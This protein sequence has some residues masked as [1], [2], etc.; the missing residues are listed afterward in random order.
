MRVDKAERAGITVLT[1]SG[2]MPVFDSTFRE[3]VQQCLSE[4]RLRFLVDLSG[5]TSVSDFGIGTVVEGLASARRMGGELKLLRPSASFAE[6]L[7][8]TRLC[9]VFEV[10]ASEEEAL[11]SFRSG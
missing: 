10:Y 4:G 11:G 9:F 8:I 3:A 1:V 6:I 7:E 2:D 5:V